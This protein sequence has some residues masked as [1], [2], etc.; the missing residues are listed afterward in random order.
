LTSLASWRENLWPL[1][2]FKSFKPFERSGTV[3][4]LERFEL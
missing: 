3:E 2:A 1:N 4:Q